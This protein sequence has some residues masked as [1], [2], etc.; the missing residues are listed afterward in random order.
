MPYGFKSWQDLYHYSDEKRAS[1]EMEMAKNA[2]K[3]PTGTA[4]DRAVLDND[5]PKALALYVQIES[6]YLRMKRNKD[7]DEAAR[8]EKLLA[9]SRRV[10]KG[11]SVTEEDLPEDRFGN[12]F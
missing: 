8:Y 6:F 1:F 3:D 2:E 4:F 9:L 12:K 11:H 5:K 10:H 7:Y